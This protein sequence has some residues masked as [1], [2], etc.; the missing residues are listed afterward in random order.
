[1]TGR[2]E[3]VT[4]S[5][6]LLAGIAREFRDSR[7]FEGM[8]IGTGIH[9]EPKTAV[10]L[11]TLQ[12]GGARVVSTGNLNSTQAET[13]DYLR[14]HGIEVVGGQT[15]DVNAH[16]VDLTAVLEVHPHLILDNGGDLFVR[17]LQNPYD[18]LRGGTEET[19][20][21]RMRLEKLRDE[22][23]FPILVINDSP[24]KQFAENEHAVG[25]SVFESFMR[26]TNRSTQGK[27]VV[28]F[29]YGACGRGI[30]ANFRNA[31]SLVTVID[32]NPV[33]LLKACLDG[34]D[35]QHREQALRKADVV[36]TAT[37]AYGV[38]RADDLANL[39]DDVILANAGH[40]PSEIDVD[41][42]LH[43]PS[44]ASVTPSTPGLQTLLTNDGRRIHLLGEGHM[45]NLAGPNPLGNSIES[46]DLGF[47]LQARCLEVIATG[48]VDAHAVVVPVPRH[49][50]EMVAEAY[51]NL[52]NGSNSA[53]SSDHRTMSAS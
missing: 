23:K 53:S 20:S 9:L 43:D 44:I 48:N 37:G 51:L 6:R 46:M 5:C 35:V 1:M 38:V 18:G 45:V 10:L 32:T 42:L 28:V 24:I 8:T 27:R 26:I 22:L 11:R 30:A 52:V 19:T 34:F 3:W 17:Y 29:G 13:V 50:D 21:G 36:I 14:E 16:G 49:I 12:E 25:Q 2:I 47:A 7:P 15:R 39:K 4:S 31:S 41:G 33:T 40:F